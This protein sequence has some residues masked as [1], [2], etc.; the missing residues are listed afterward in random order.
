[1]CGIAFL[2][3]LCT[4]AM[5]HQAWHKHQ[6]H[7][8]HQFKFLMCQH[9]FHLQYLI[10]LCYQIVKIHNI[11]CQG[12]Y[13]YTFFK[14]VSM[15][16]V[17][18]QWYLENMTWTCDLPRNH[19]TYLPNQAMLMTVFEVSPQAWKSTQIPSQKKHRSLGILSYV[20][21]LFDDR[22]KSNILDETNVDTWGTW[23]GD[24]SGLMWHCCEDPRI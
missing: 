13:A 18:A 15:C 4:T 6:T 9:W 10:Y 8:G 12:F 19:A 7:R 16:I 2:R 11:I 1:M 17:H 3:F 22:N 5:P 21:L 23:T 20:F 14:M 24:L